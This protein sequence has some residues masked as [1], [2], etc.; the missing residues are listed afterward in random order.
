MQNGE[1]AEELSPLWETE[2]GLWVVFKK[3]NSAEET[4][5]MQRISAN[6]ATAS[7]CDGN[8]ANLRL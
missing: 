2:G 3:L 4:Q 7:L 8:S 6:P 5:S 1:G